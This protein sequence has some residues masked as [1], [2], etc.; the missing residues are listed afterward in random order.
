[1]GKGYQKTVKVGVADS[2]K[3]PYT[4]LEMDMK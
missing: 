2:N 3:V 4:D 1:M